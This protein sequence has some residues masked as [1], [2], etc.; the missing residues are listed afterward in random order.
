[1][2]F[3]GHNEQSCKAHQFSTPSSQ[4]A[5]DLLV[6]VH[7]G[8]GMKMTQDKS[9]SRSFWL[10]EGGKPPLLHHSGI[11]V[12]YFAKRGEE[13]VSAFRASGLS[14]S[15]VVI[16]ERDERAY[17]QACVLNVETASPLSPSP[18]TLSAQLD[19]SRTSEESS[20]RTL[21]SLGGQT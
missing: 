7:L 14:E 20:L 15:K 16:R 10:Q 6:W 17:M 1:M 13:R 21:T 18:R 3:K 5:Q 19:L 12:A 8:V 2:E 9:C 11:L 4:K